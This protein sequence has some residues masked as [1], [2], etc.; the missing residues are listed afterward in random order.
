MLMG[1]LIHQDIQAQMKRKYP[2]LL[3]EFSGL[4]TFDKYEIAYHV[5]LFDPIQRC[6]YEIKSDFRLSNYLD[7]VKAQ[8][9]MYAYL[10][11]ATKVKLL[12]YKVVYDVF[13]EYEANWDRGA[14]LIKQALAKLPQNYRVQEGNAIEDSE[15]MIT[16]TEVRSKLDEFL[17][18]QSLDEL[19]QKILDYYTEL[20]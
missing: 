11:K 17:K 20:L 16:N 5:D 15:Y 12:N 3:P 9:D 18:C 19:R 7:K 2:S 10:T 4:F 8:S 6:L 1:K 14:Y 13:E